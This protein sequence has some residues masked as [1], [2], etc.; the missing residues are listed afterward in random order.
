METACTF[1]FDT[2]RQSP[3]SALVTIQAASLSRDNP[4]D[5]ADVLAFVPDRRHADL[6][7]L[8][9]PAIDE[10]L[11]HFGVHKPEVNQDHEASIEVA[12]KI[13]W[14]LVRNRKTPPVPELRQIIFSLHNILLSLPVGRSQNFIS[15]TCEWL[16]TVLDPERFRV[17]PQTLLYLL[18]RSFGDETYL[19]CG[20]SRIIGGAASDLRRVYSIRKAFNE[21]E[22]R[23]DNSGSETIHNLLL[24]CATSP[25]YLSSTDGRKFLACLLSLD[26]IRDDIFDALIRQ[27]AIVRK[28]IAPYFG[29]VF[30]H[31]WSTNRSDWLADRFI[32]VS[33]K[34]IRAACDPFA[35][36][37]RI[38]MS[39]F[40]FNKRMNGVD[41]LLHQIYSPTL[42]GNL[43]VANPFVRKNAVTI[44]ADAFPL[45]D[46]GAR[47]EDI[48]N[49]IEFQC[50]KLL[51]LLTDPAPIVRCA[52]VKGVCKILTLYWEL[53]PQ[54]AGKKMLDTITTKLAFDSSSAA[55]RIAVFEGLRGLID[56]HLAHPSLGVLLPHLRPLVDD[57]IE[58]VRLGVL[59]LLLKIKEKR[60]K[61]LRYFDVVPVDDLL[62][63]L[64]LE[65]P[66]VALKIMSLIVTSYFPLGKEGKSAE[67]AAM[68]Q[69]KA[70]FSILQN[71]E[72]AGKYFYGNVNMYVPPGPLCEFALRLS[73]HA[74]DPKTSTTARKRNEQGRAKPRRGGRRGRNLRSNSNDENEPPVNKN[75]S[76]TAENGEAK[77]SAGD[78]LK[79]SDKVV[80]KESLLMTVADVLV[81]I[82][83]SL[84][85]EKNAEL[86][87]Y[88][89]NIFS[90]TALLPYLA[91]GGNSIRSRIAV[92]RIASCISPS[93]IKSVTVL[94][95]E[96][97]DCVVDW[98]RKTETDAHNYRE[99]L[100]AMSLCAFRWKLI[101]T[102]LAVVSCWSECAGQGH[103][104]MRIGSKHARKS[105]SSKA[106]SKKGKK[107]GPM[108]YEDKPE[109]EEGILSSRASSLFALQAFG[110]IIMNDDIGEVRTELER[111]MAV[112]PDDAGQDDTASSPGRF[113]TC[114]RKGSIGAFDHLL[115]TM[116]DGCTKDGVKEYPLLLKTIVVGLQASLTFAIRREAQDGILQDLKEI[117]QWLGG[118]D[119]WKNL[120]RVDGFF[121]HTLLSVCLGPIADAAALKRFNKKDLEIIETISTYMA[122]EWE[123]S[124]VKP[125]SR[126]ASE[127]LRLAF[128]LEE[129]AAH[130][131]EKK[132]KNPNVLSESDLRRSAC[133]IISNVLDMLK[134][135][136]A[137]EGKELGEAFKPTELQ[138]FLGRGLVYVSQ[139]QDRPEFAKVFGCHFVSHFEK[140]KDGKNSF[141]ASTVC[142]AMRELFT[143]PRWGDSSVA[144]HVF[145]FAWNSMRN[146]STPL[147]SR[148]V[149]M[150][151]FVTS[152]LKSAQ[153]YY[154]AENKL[155]TVGAREF[156]AM[157]ESTVDN[158]FSRG[159]EPEDVTE[160][161]GEVRKALSLLKNLQE[162]DVPKAAA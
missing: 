130:P 113:V 131:D 81:S 82:G 12:S 65:P 151:A 67:D 92:W 62:Q 118:E 154:E 69:V 96:Q 97:M 74:L 19:V 100:S 112:I 32:H 8:L 66:A 47:R 75:I 37:L 42:F 116:Q 36:N 20:Q 39:S 158:T 148:N 127:L 44:L 117:L 17:L 18:M 162:S 30:L 145:S 104:S 29:N 51:E 26:D 146:E 93:R 125:V 149:A 7:F 14:L 137:D 153:S 123:V 2:L 110:S 77:S 48:E 86:R 101:P 41:F 94:W 70:C 24:R 139:A 16:W 35:S 83:P 59:E 109:V 144:S 107:G 143:N 11:I 46:P 52:T 99:L 85:K 87:E 25:A 115:E 28:T 13:I 57:N 22:L 71:Y 79:K 10:P 147:T 89:D 84:E 132:A 68:L 133:S 122:N 135:G 40:H 63:R 73:S 72:D 160:A 54:L 34:A 161:I 95:R 6:A 114:I 128:Q 3:S 138:S 142:N 106:T 56:N 136:E 102:L 150:V 33:E 60:L 156:L 126:A 103:R 120:R 88:V 129:Q 105:R 91:V 108:I 157:V 124:S 76:A 121:G 61:T 38:V 1:L 55:V 159:A 5:L 58:K 152:V 98:S 27:L 50:T 45:H 78:D 141:V 111:A 49:A 119:M 90:G 43:M 4:F 155:P 23:V 53:I 31:A 9:L 64:P 134:I 80:G 21:I 15:Q 140:S